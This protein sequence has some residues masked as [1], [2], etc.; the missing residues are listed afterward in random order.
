MNYDQLKARQRAER[1]AH[2]PK[3]A[4]CVHRAISWLQRAEQLAL[5]DN[6]D[7][8]FI[9]LWIAF[10]AAKSP[11]WR[12]YAVQASS[13]AYVVRVREWHSRNILVHYEMLLE[14]ADQFP[15]YETTQ[16]E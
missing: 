5:P 8:E 7:G 13:K 6:K 14:R 16:E 4:L 2:H 9:L 11:K 12:R 1:H 10:N 15:E 3:L